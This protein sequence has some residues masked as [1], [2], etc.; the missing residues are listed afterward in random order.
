MDNEKYIK[1]LRKRYFELDKQYEKAKS[2]RTLC[3]L[4]AFVVYTF[5]LA[6]VAIQP[7]STNAFGAALLIAVVGGG[8][9]FWGCTLIMIPF[10][11]KGRDEKEML[12]EIKQKVNELEGVSLP[13]MCINPNEPALLREFRKLT[14]EEQ[15]KLIAWLERKTVDRK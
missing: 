15:K 8:I 14:E 3:T 9:Q 7:N 5:V 1:Y 4:A 11:N 2:Q 10:I 13:K 6:C 12:E